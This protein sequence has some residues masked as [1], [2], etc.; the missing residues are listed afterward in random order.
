MKERLGD[1]PRAD[2]MAARRG[3]AAPRASSISS[4]EGRRLRRRVEGPEV[5]RGST[6]RTIFG[7][8]RAS[9]ATSSSSRCADVDDEHHGELPRR[10]AREGHRRRDPSRAPR[11]ARINFKLVPVIC[12]SAF[13]NKGVQMLLDAVVNYLPSP[14][15]I[16]PVKGIDPRRRASRDRTRKAERRRTRSARSRSRS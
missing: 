10:A 7:R 12:G 15:D 6:S 5:R 2:P 8:S 3:R 4:D 11:T 16:P 1:Q 14:L 9:G 13:K